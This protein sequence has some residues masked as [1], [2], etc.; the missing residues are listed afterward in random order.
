MDNEH[1]YI[2]KKEDNQV[3]STKTYS[4]VPFPE[5]SFIPP[6]LLKNKADSHALGVHEKCALV[7]VALGVLAVFSWVVLLFGVLYSAVGII[8]SIIGLRSTRKKLAKIGLAL[9][10]LGLVLSILYIFAIS[11]GI[12]NFNYFTSEFWG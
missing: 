2:T 11:Q 9:S 10:I 7:G 8:L 4:T 6:E 1:L 12:I 5:I 3:D